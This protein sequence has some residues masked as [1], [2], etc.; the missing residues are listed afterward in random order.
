MKQELK[1]AYDRMNPPPGAKERMMRNIQN[2]NKVDG[3]YQSEP[4]VSHSWSAIPALLVL[5]V[6]LAVG[7]WMLIPRADTPVS[8][9]PTEPTGPEVVHHDI[10]D[11]AAMFPDMPEEYREILATYYTALAGKYDEAYWENNGLNT[12]AFSWLDV[13]DDL[14]YAL[15]DLDGNGNEELLITDGDQV[16]DLYTFIDGEVQ[17]LLKHRIEYQGKRVSIKLCEDNI[18][19]VWQR[20]SGMDDYITWYRLGKDGLG[21]TALTSVET[22]FIV[23]TDHWYAGPNEKD[24][25][26]VTE[27]RAREILNSRE[28]VTIDLLPICPEKCKDNTDTIPEGYAYILDKYVRAQVDN[29]TVE[30][31]ME[32]DIS[33][34]LKDLDI[35]CDYGYTLIDLNSDGVKELLITDGELIYDIFILME[36][37]GAGHLATGWERNRL[38]W[39]KGNFILNEQSGGASL[40]AYV[41]YQFD[42]LDLMTVQAVAYD[43]LAVNGPWYVGDTLDSMKSATASDAQAVFDA[44]E[45]EYLEFIPMVQPGG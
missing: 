33:Y 10:L 45:K 39:C 26:E 9:D 36:D 44:Y 5:A 19:M 25:V 11:L 17:E 41:Y 4:T 12:A 14:G 37:G 3:K 40:T 15:M 13:I 8:V 7:W 35:T 16:Y 43:G 32:N 42:G 38:Y 29:W 31:Y 30:Q 27:E 18:V 22:V 2:Q 21:M 24:A 28:T 23:D 20:S 34:A 1:N 6:V